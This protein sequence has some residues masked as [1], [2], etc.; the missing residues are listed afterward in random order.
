MRTTGIL[1]KP[2]AQLGLIFGYLVLIPALII[3]GYVLLQ[4]KYANFVTIFLSIVTEALPFLLIGSIVSGCIHL[5]VDQQLLFRFLPRH[6]LPGA[7]VGA[8]LGIFFPVCECGVIPV[9]R[10][11]YQKGM[12]LS[13]GIAFMLSAPVVNPIVM[14]STY[15]AFGW[16]PMLFF[17]PLLSFTI[18]GSIGWLFSLAAPQEVLLPSVTGEKTL[19]DENP[20]CVECCH[21][22]REEALALSL[23]GYFYEALAVAGDDFLDMIRYVIVGSFIAASLQTLIPQSAFLQLR[24][25]VGTSALI[26]ML[27]AFVLSVCSTADAFLALAFTT[28]FPSA[29]VLAFLVFGPMIDI[30]STLMLLRVFRYKAILYLFLLAALMTLCGTMAL[31]LHGGW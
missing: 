10:R 27:M 30:K 11:L 28:T 12:P 15:A 24:G 5:F 1:H 18:A 29:A 20:S 6:P 2:S 3:V 13:V 4:D 31:S 16:G 21:A 23:K 7:L 9:I 17:R 8:V 25:N 22:R 14:V 26:M 19:H